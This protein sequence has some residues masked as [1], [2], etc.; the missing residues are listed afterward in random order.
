LTFTLSALKEANKRSNQKQI[1]AQTDSRA[2]A[3]RAAIGVDG[4]DHEE[5]EDEEAGCVPLTTS[6]PPPL[7][8]DGEERL[9]VR[10]RG[11]S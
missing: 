6:E 10:V 11:L 4:F 2:A 3:T 7:V 9:G 5:D 8:W 1:S